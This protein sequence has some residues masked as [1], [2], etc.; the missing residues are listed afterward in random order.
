MHWEAINSYYCNMG[1]FVLDFNSL[2]YP[3]ADGRAETQ[4]PVETSA[5]GQHTV[6]TVDL[7]TASDSNI[8]S[9]TATA[10]KVKNT[11][12][13][14]FGI[15]SS[16][17]GPPSGGSIMTKAA[18]RPD[19]IDSVVNRHS[20][21]KVGGKIPAFR[22]LIKEGIEQAEYPLSRKQEINLSRT[23]CSLWALNLNQIDSAIR[24]GL[25]DS[26]PNVSPRDLDSLNKGDALVKFLAIVQVS[27]LIIQMIA[28]KIARL[29]SSQLDIAALAFS[30]SS[31]ITYLL[32]LEPS[33]RR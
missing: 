19:I 26:L 18:S 31:L 7:M 6:R 29:P 16:M 13:P 27:R 11:E 2:L 21:G 14:A 25:I 9:A 15:S 33:A 17:P 32:F 4:L 5:P 22:Q 3:A 24:R 12:Q 10:N 1:E 28:R 8:T 23:Q 30:A 20:Q